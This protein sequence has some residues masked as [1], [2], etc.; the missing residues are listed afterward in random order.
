MKYIVGLS[1]GA[2]SSALLHYLVSRGER[3][4]AAHCNFHLRGAESDR[5][6]DVSRKL[7]EKLGVEFRVK[8]F[9][10]A[11]RQQCTGESVEMACRNLRYDWWRSLI[12]A[13]VGDRIAV[14]HHRDD[15]IETLMLNL[16]RGSGLTGLKAMLPEEGDVVRPLLS[17]SRKDTEQYCQQHGIN[18]VTDSTNTQCDYARN[19]I[20]NLILPLIEREFPT[21]RAG[22]SKSLDILQENYGFYREKMLQVQSKALGDG[23]IRI[24]GLESPLETFEVLKPLGFNYAQSHEIWEKRDR[25]GLKFIAAGMTYK[26]W[27]GILYCVNEQEEC[28]E[29]TDLMQAPFE[30]SYGQFEQFHPTKDAHELYLSQTALDNA[31]QWEWRSWREGDRFKPFGMKGRSRL[32]SDLLTDA[33]LNPVE[34]SKVRVLARNGEIVWVWPLRTSDLFRV[35]NEPFVRFSLSGE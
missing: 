6:E 31:P 27:E 4:V 17:W 11:A 22:L 2:D 23:L 9:D 8:H 34:K 32:V 28:L 13:G 26:L 35:K 16:L 14:A 19:K 24:Q 21:S 12:A 1:G 20:R 25:N 5:D 15:N 30:V 33:H 29:F 7:A 10:V 18:Y 3:C